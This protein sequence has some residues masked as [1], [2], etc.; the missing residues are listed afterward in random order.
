MFREFKG[1]GI[2]NVPDLGFTNTLNDILEAC[3]AVYMTDG[4]ISLSRL[5]DVSVDLIFSQAVLEHVRKDE[6]KDTIKEC[7]RILKPEGRASHRIDLK[8]HLDSS[9]NNLQFSEKL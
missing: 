3:G 9:L 1:M 2:P 8:D 6:F 5:D 4:N 7:Y